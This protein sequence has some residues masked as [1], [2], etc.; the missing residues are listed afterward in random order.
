VRF[1][2]FW[3]RDNASQ[4][5]VA[6]GYFQQYWELFAANGIP[7]R[8]HWGNFIP[9]YDLGR[10]AEH[11]RASLP[12]SPTSWSCAPAATPAT[13]SSPATGATESPTPT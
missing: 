9:A 5:N 12:R 1:D 4:P 3:F 13:S 10:W 2:V 7:F 8:F 6:G 11:Y